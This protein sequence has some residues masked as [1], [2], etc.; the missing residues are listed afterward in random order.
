MP[1]AC[2]GN[3]SH[4]LAHSQLYTDFHTQPHPAKRNS[5]SSV[6]RKATSRKKGG[7]G[8]VRLRKIWR[9]ETKPKKWGSKRDQFRAEAPHLFVFP[10]NLLQSGSGLR[11][12]NRVERKT[13]ATTKEAEP[14]A[15][16][17]QS[18]M[19]AI[20]IG[21]G[22]GEGPGRGG[23]EGGVETGR[24]GRCGTFEKTATTSAPGFS[25]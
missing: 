24:V 13:S 10:Y 16:P 7:N 4:H 14:Q 12:S 23:R 1:E 5:Q 6:T 17:P 3:S 19:E 20:K 15:R 2:F 21:L 11:S 18:W 22:E 8:Y 25:S 9:R